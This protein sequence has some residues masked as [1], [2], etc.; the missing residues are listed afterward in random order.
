MHEVSI[1]TEAFQIRIVFHDF[2]VTK[3]NDTVQVLDKVM[4]PLE[5]QSN[6]ETG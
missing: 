3:L 6:E 4:F 2:T 1:A 5:S